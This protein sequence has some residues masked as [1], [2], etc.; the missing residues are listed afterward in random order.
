MLK[1]LF[2]NLSL[3]L[4]FDYIRQSWHMKQNKYS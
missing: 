2:T 1:L 4:N 3:I